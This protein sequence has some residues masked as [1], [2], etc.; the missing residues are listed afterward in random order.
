METLYRYFVCKDDIL[1]KI[2]LHFTVSLTDDT[3]KYRAMF[4][5]KADK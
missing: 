1:N 2:V 5:L 4:L 3:K